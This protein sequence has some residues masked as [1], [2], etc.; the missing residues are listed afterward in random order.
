MNGESDAYLARFYI[1]FA[2]LD[3]SD[4]ALDGLGTVRRNRVTRERYTSS[5]DVRYS[6]ENK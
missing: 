2:D 1:L 3:N 4:A 5:K 6:Y